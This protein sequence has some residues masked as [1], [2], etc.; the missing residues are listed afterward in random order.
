MYELEMI[1]CEMEKFSVERH[2]D[3]V[4]NDDVKMDVLSILTD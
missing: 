3:G 1:S 2:D 4:I